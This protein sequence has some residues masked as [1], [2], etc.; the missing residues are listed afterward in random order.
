[1]LDVESAYDNVKCDLLVR[2]L[3]K[4]KCP[5]RI[6]RIIQGSIHL[7]EG[8]FVTNDGED[9]LIRTISKGLPQG[10]VLSPTL[11]ALYTHDIVSSLEEGVDGLQFADDIVIFSRGNNKNTLKDKLVKSAI[12][13]KAQLTRLGLDLQTDKTEMIMFTGRKEN[14]SVKDTFCI[15]DT[16]DELKDCVKFLGIWL[17]SELNFRK[18]LENVSSK[19]T[20]ANRLIRFMMGIKWGVESDTAL[21][22]YKNMVRSTIDYGLFI[23]FPWEA[24]TRTVLERAQYSGLRLAMGY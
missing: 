21:M 2:K 15:G 13:I 22:L 3:I 11:Y 12:N 10:A 1:M 5:S 18:Q 19:V 14:T 24:K 16:T 7:R 6:I 17:D 8:H 9:I 23:Y 4:M 20:K